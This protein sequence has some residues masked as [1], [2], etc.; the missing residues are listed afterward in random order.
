MHLQGVGA[1]SSNGSDLGDSED[2]DG[3]F[4]NLLLDDMD[5]VDV[6]GEIESPLVPSKATPP[7]P[8]RTPVAA[9]R[10]RRTNSSG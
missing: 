7:P 4:D 5:R 10:N 8:T 6:E 1:Y 2:E 9:S 3:T